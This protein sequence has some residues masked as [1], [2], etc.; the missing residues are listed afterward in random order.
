MKQLLYILFAVTLFT[1]CSSDDD[2]SSPIRLQGTWWEAYDDNTKMDLG[3][4]TD[5]TCVLEFT[6]G[7]TKISADY[8]CEYSHPNIIFRPSSSKYNRM[9]GVIKSEH[10]MNISTDKAT[11]SFTR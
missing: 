2:K 5:S 1:A 6:I 8:K 9:N 10:K 4:Y 7:N 11:F 3:F